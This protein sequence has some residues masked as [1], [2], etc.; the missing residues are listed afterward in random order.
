MEYRS[1]KEDIINYFNSEAISQSQL[2]LLTVSSQAFLEVK[3]PEKFF[4]EKE[5]FVIGSAVDD[6]ITM[7]ETY[8]DD[9]YFVSKLETKPSDTIKSIVQQVFS[10]KENDD[11]FEQRLSILIAI[12]A[13]NYQPNWKPETKIAKVSEEGEAYW[14]ELVNSEGKQILSLEEYSLITKIVNQLQEHE[15]V[16]WVFQKE[17]HIDI[18]YQL[19]IYFEIQNTYCKALL[20]MVIVNHQDKTIQ[21]ID[22]KTLGD[23]TKNFPY[24][25]KK[26]RYDIQASWYT[27]AIKYWR[28]LTHKDYFIHNFT[29]I[30]ASTTRTCPPLT[31][32]M[33]S[34]AL[35]IGKWGCTLQSTGTQL[36][37]KG[38]LFKKEIVGWF[39][40]LQLY[41]FHVENGFEVD[42]EIILADGHFIIEHDYNKTIA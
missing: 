12:E 3:E 5:H 41:D 37:Q 39:E 28:N 34:D 10:Q 40:L 11:W 20:D 38:F 25:V 13:H 24:H 14:Y 6:W 32:T 23:Y 26:R 21:P 35:S 22:F 18:Y 31:F 1:T 8:F 19:P 16:N 4:E 7:G 17:G 42:Q 15:Y 27:E 2:K 36:D 29:F 9:N 33:S 30:V